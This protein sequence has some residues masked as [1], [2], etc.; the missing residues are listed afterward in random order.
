MSSAKTQNIFSIMTSNIN[1][2][3]SVRPKLKTC[4]RKTYQFYDENYPSPENQHKALGAVS[5]LF[6]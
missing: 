5:F 2:L 6:A 4:P 1:L 3:I